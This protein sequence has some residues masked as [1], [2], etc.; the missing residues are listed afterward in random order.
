MADTLRNALGFVPNRKPNPRS[1]GC[2]G[3]AVS[4][5]HW[6][7]ESVMVAATK[8]WNRSA[9][10]IWASADRAAKTDNTPTQKSALFATL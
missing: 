8:G 2:N 4:G 5:T 3:M 7:V 9:V 10:V 6:A 1:S